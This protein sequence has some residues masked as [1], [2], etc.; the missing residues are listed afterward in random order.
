V[1]CL[2][3][4]GWPILRSRLSIPQKAMALI[5]VSSYLTH[6]LMLVV[7]LAS[8]P[9]LWVA[10]SAREPFIGLGIAGLGPPLVY[11]VAQSCLYRDWPRRMLYFP[12]L[13]AVA[14][15]ITWSTSAAVWQGLTRWGGTFARTP[16]F[17]IEGRQ[18]VWRDS[19]YRLVPDWTV[20][21]E[22]ALMAYAAVT[23]V[24]AYT[25]GN[26]GA[27]PFLLIYVCGYG[28]V[29]GSSLMQGRRG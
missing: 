12:V 10:P 9:L 28:L 27:V 24:L 1:Q 16:K 23:A 14:A 5:H 19:L 22:L 4:L 11:A 7:L 17:R 3:K 25:R 6:P 20:I 8:L 26:L 2:R 15:G 29:A 13:A 21:G 18:G